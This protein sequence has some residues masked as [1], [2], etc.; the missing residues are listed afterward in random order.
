MLPQNSYKLSDRPT[1]RNLENI[2]KILDD[3]K[4]ILIGGMAVAAYANHYGLPYN[5]ETKDIDFVIDK[6][7]K[8]HTKE[9]IYKELQNLSIREG[10]I[11]GYDGMEITY[12]DGPKVSILFKDGEVPYNEIKLKLGKKEIKLYV[13]KMEYLFVDKIF[14]YLNRKER[15]DSEDIKVLYNLMKK[16]GY[17]KELLYKIFSEYSKR[18]K[19]YSSKAK[20]IIE[21]I[22]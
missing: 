3:V 4:P 11:F 14:T 10:Q 13:A 21:K 5:R 12:K 17:D 2:L 7:E 18:Y 20:Y 8:I 1:I 19:K 6:N 16:Y 9:I 15:K 22:L